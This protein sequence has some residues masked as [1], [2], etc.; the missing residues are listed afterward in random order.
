MV[1]RKI[2]MENIEQKVWKALKR[3]NDPELSVSVS[4]LGLI[5]KVKAKKI[6]GNEKYLIKVVMTL[7]SMG[8]P[9]ASVIESM[10]VGEVRKVAGVGRVKVEIVWEPVWT[11]EKMKPEVRAELGF[12]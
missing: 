3:V 1:I 7:T 8:C 4:D 9:L 10:I 11:P 12:D 5:Y 6:K 2:N